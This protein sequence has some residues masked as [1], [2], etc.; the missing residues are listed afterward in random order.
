MQRQELI[1]QGDAGRRTRDER[2]ARDLR[3]AQELAAKRRQAQ[4]VKDV[5][6]EAG[7]QSKCQA[8]GQ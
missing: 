3:Q 4:L 1:S 7:E 6:G 8:I 5:L 2:R